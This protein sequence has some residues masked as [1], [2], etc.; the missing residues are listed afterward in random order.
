MGVMGRY[1]LS[2]LRPFT[3]AL[4]PAE[5]GPADNGHAPSKPGKE[6]A[7]ANGEAGREP[8]KPQK[9]DHPGNGRLTDDQVKNIFS[10]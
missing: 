3:G 4:F 6:P 7:A 2:H 1:L 10:Y 5:R 8:K 9:P